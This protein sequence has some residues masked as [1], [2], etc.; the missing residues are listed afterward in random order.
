MKFRFVPSDHIAKTAELSGAVPSWVCPSTGSIHTAGILQTSEGFELAV[1]QAYALQLGSV[2][3]VVKNKLC[4]AKTLSGREIVG[5]RRPVLWQP[6]CICQRR[7]T[8][9]R[10]L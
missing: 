5:V 8:L 3:L 10:S 6:A 2:P 1:G 7:C 4:P 9:A